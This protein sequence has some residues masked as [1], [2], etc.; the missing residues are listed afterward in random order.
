[1]QYQESLGADIIMVLDEC[2]AYGDSREQVGR[3]M[4]RTHRWAEKCLASWQRRDLSLYAIVQGGMF[5]DL[6]KRSADFLAGLDFPG[7][8]I[9]GLSVGEP[10][11]TTLAMLDETVGLLPENKP[12]YLMGVGS[13]EDIVEGVARGI[14]IFDCALPTRV[15]RNGALFT[16]TGRISIRKA[17]YRTVEGPVDPAC[18]C[19]T[20][21]KFSAAYLSHLFRSEEILGL[22]LATIHNLRFIGNLMAAI[23]NAITDGKYDS[24]REE[25]LANYHPTDEQTRVEQKGKWLKGR[26]ENGQV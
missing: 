9:G 13:P 19:Y 5:P 24:F 1:M 17:V 14:D 6:R 12:R 21:R 23:R 25:F 22:R 18:D 15:A 4:E 26:E 16:S 2:S 10:K 7:Y 11:E 20:C 3:A 8:A